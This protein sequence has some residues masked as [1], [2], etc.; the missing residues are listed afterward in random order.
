MITNEQIAKITHEANRA[1]CAVIGDDSQVAWE[2]APEWQ[3]NSAI[4]GVQ[5]NR[6]NPDAPPSASHDSW[7]EV[8]KAEG[9]KYGVVKNAELKEHPCY[10]PYE[11][12]PEEQKK[13]DALFKAVVAALI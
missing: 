11:D 6:E 1:Y 10:V 7:L 13:K 4:I 8:K 5:F 2:E 12:L 3:R 9:W